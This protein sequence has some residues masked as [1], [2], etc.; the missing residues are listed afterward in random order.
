MAKAAS[1]DSVTLGSSAKEKPET[2]NTK[3]E[4]RGPRPSKKQASRKIKGLLLTE[5]TIQMY[6]VLKGKRGPNS[7]P[8]LAEEAFALLFERYKKDLEGFYKPLSS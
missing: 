7:G 4:N 2:A 1:L 8:V 5:D 3:Q 6:D